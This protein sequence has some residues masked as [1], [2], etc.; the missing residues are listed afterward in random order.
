MLRA[1][2]WPCQWRLRASVGLAAH[3]SPCRRYHTLYWSVGVQP[4]F[5]HG[6]TTQWPCVRLIGRC[7]RI[8][9]ATDGALIAWRLYPALEDGLITCWHRRLGLR[10]RCTR[11]SRRL[12]QP[13]LDL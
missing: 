6:C 10:R 8:G 12:D 2:R 1:E 13:R 9:T 3:L 11:R 4:A 7:T 5:R